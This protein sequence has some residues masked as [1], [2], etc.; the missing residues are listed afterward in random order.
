MRRPVGPSPTS[1]AKCPCSTVAVRLHGKQETVSSILTSGFQRACGV[2]ALH[3]ALSKL[4]YEFDPRHARHIGTWFSWLERHNDIVETAG[5]SPA[6]PTR[7]S[8]TY[9]SSREQVFQTCYA[10]ATRVVGSK[11]ASSSN[12][13]APV[14]HAGGCRCKSDLVHHI[15][16]ALV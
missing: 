16:G 15:L 1:P 10:R 11:W 5:S 8:P 4:R 2:A 3:M 9:L 13:R 12:K 6:V 14:L 7:Y